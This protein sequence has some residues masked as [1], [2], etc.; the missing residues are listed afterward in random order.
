MDLD[1]RFRDAE[2]DRDQLVAG[3]GHQRL[4]DFLLTG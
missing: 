1:G 2:P 3:A 4:K